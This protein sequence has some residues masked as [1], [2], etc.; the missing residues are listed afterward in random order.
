MSRVLQMPQRLNSLQPVAEREFNSRLIDSIIALRL[1][2]KDWIVRRVDRITFLDTETTRKDSEFHLIIPRG[3]PTVQLEKEKEKVYLLPLVTFERNVP[4]RSLKVADESGSNLSTLTKE[5]HRMVLHQIFERLQ[6]DASTKLEAEDLERIFS[7]S[8]DRGP[9]LS[10]PKVSGSGKEREVTNWWSEELEKFL[11]EKIPPEEIALRTFAIDLWL[12]YIHLVVV[13]MTDHGKEGNRRRV[14]SLSHE[15][16]VAPHD[17]PPNREGSPSISELSQLEGEFGG[18][19]RRLRG[20]LGLRE[21]RWGIELGGKKLRPVEW[22]RGWLEPQWVRILW[23]KWY[24]DEYGSCHTEI[25]V[26]PELE[27]R[28]AFLYQR[29]HSTEGSPGTSGLSGPGHGE[30]EHFKGEWSLYT[31][32]YTGSSAHLLKMGSLNGWRLRDPSV[33][34]AEC[35]RCGKRKTV[36]VDEYCD[37][38]QEKVGTVEDSSRPALRRGFLGWI[39]GQ[40]KD[41]YVVAEKRGRTKRRELLSRP[42]A[43]ERGLV[44]IISIILSARSEALRRSAMAVGAFSVTMLLLA[45]LLILLAGNDTLK[46]LPKGMP[47]SLEVLATV[48]VFAPTVAAAVI[49]QRAAHPMTEELTARLRDT[50]VIFGVLPIF[51]VIILALTKEL[52]PYQWLSHEVSGAI[53]AALLLLGVVLLG[54]LWLQGK[55]E[56]QIDPEP[57]PPSSY[58]LPEDG[59]NSSG[60]DLDPDREARRLVQTSLW[61]QPAK[62]RVVQSVEG[63]RLPAASFYLAERDGKKGKDHL[64]GRHGWL[65]D[66]AL[67]RSA[68]RFA[69]SA[70]F[71]LS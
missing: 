1:T 10:V 33:K 39:R 46:S 58:W 43:T 32:A 29:H 38:C 41:P 54:V 48:L 13:P 7:P 65:T 5:E 37:E 26:P 2:Y 44:A 64:D 52:G 36:S 25:D 51:A 61:A 17:E 56:R 11:Q 70:G 50:I 19:L 28:Q 55:I 34:I 53:L 8:P 22:L 27:V 35:L 20:L 62:T 68:R 23:A 67:R 9:S 60:Q 18:G 63:L 4:L 16:R 71:D 21:H 31:S 12:G 3:L 66:G 30:N 45:G 49:S 42:E 57:L 14:I 24:D 6:Q 40:R 69:E 59:E 15:E 47:L